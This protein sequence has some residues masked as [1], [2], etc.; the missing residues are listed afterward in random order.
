MTGSTWSPW[1]RAEAAG[2]GAAS[3]RERGLSK[4]RER[5]GGARRRRAVVKR[6]AAIPAKRTD[7]YVF[8]FVWERTAEYDPQAK[9]TK[10]LALSESHDL[11]VYEFTREDGKCG[12]DPLHSCREGVL[13]K[14]LEANSISEYFHVCPYPLA[15]AVVLLRVVKQ[16]QAQRQGGQLVSL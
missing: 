10:I 1:G 14:L 16:G 6:R 5:E 7:G 11:F 4:C 8:S 15:V 12:P 9:R 13:K 2:R 3:C